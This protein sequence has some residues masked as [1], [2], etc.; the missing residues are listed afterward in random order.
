MKSEMPSTPSLPTP[1]IS[2]E[3]PDV[4]QSIYL[5]KAL[6]VV[7]DDSRQKIVSRRVLTP[8]GTEEGGGGGADSTVDQLRKDYATKFGQP[9]PQ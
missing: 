4:L 1:A 3:T 7:N 6:Q 9:L 5:R 8:K 2:A